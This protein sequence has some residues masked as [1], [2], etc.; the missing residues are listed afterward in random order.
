MY[1]EIRVDVGSD[2]PYPV[3]NISQFN[4]SHALLCYSSQPV[5]NKMERGERKGGKI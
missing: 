5:C 4:H 2:V 3:A 1:Q